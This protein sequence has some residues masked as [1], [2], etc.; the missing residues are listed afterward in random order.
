MIYE[1]RATMFFT[2]R[3]EAVDFIHD[4]SIA[5]TKAVVVN[6]CLDNQQC[7]Q[8]DG[9]FCHHDNHPPEACTLDY[10]EDNCPVCPPPAP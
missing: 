3:D 6:P 1:V 7:S 5:L 8:V 4:C 2:E 9:I 10:H